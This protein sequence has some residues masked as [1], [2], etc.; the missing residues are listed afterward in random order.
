MTMKTPEVIPGV[1]LF[2]RRKS[3]GVNEYAFH[4]RKKGFNAGLYCTPGGHNEGFETYEDCAIREADE[5]LGVKLA[6]R[7]LQPAHLLYRKGNKRN[8]L[9]GSAIR[10]DMC[11]VIERWKGE[12][13]NK[14]PKKYGDMEWCPFNDIPKN[15]VNYVRQALKHIENGVFYSTHGF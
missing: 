3:E 8:K 7:D 5:E 4:E 13:Q 6:K 2:F 1:L 15:T 14:E 10:P 11:F 12:F 9:N